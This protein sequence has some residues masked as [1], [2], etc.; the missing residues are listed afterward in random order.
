MSQKQS[1]YGLNLSRNNL[2]KNS[3]QWDVPNLIISPHIS[4]DD[5]ASYVD[6]TLSL[7]FDNLDRF[8]S[9]KSLLNTVDKKL[10]Y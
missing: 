3:K 7:F 8:I 1:N 4:A 10:G 9:N 2:D 5:G 6:N